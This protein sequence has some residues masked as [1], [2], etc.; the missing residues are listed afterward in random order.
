[1]RLHR[2]AFALGLAAL[3]AGCVEVE[4]EAPLFAG[5]RPL[6]G[7]WEVFSHQRLVNGRVAS[8][9]PEMAL[10]RWE[11]D[12]YILVTASQGPI[13]DLT[14]HRV[15]AGLFV[16]QATERGGWLSSPV[17]VYGIARLQMD[18][19]WVLVPVAAPDGGRGCSAGGQGRCRLSSRDAVIA[20]ARATAARV[21]QGRAT[22]ALVFWETDPI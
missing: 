18:G 12:R 20:A 10:I 1:M 3:A 19:V 7:A 11:G 21:D 17:T 14:L 2:I 4:S 22:G 8:P 15:D 16:V 5:A 9:A 13:R 6:P